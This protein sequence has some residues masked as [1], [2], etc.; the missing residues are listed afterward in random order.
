MFHAN[1]WDL[2]YDAF[3][4]YETLGSHKLTNPFA[5]KPAMA[6]MLLFMSEIGIID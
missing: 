3:P 6:A 5:R 2:S 4:W 1:H